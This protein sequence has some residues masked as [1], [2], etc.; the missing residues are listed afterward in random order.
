MKKILLL[1]AL[2][3]STVVV[4]QE[5]CETPQEE[6]EDLNS[7]TKCS[8]KPSGK[9]KDK[10]SRQISVKVSASTKRY[11]KKR[12]AEK[13][14]VAS[15]ASNLSVSGVS[16]TNHSSGISSDLSLKKEESTSDF[17]SSLSNSLSA[18][19]VRAANKFNAVDKIPLFLSCEKVKK[20]EQLGCFNTEMVKHINKHFRYPNEAIINKV[21]GNVWVRFII[22][23]NGHVT[24][25]K[26]LGPKGAKILDQEAIRV[27]SK[28][29]KFVPG[30][31]G[32][33]KTSVK[34]GFPISF[35]LED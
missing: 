30:T 3:I 6:L 24:N 17:I 18:E 23:K 25:I 5:T 7:I 15:S 33:S 21:Q 13:K 34:Y 26:A 16:S 2:S 10:D 35:S 11:L 12:I 22:D 32:G 4:S 28:L 8:I 14:S 20:K 9:S 31:K 27:V 1:L 29:P 19:E